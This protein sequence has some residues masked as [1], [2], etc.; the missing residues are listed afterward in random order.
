MSRKFLIICSAASLLLI[1]MSASARDRDFGLGLVLGEPTGVSG[2]IWLGRTTALDG[3]VAW[4]TGRDDDLQLQGD[5]VWHD[6]GLFDVDRGALPLY[7]GVGGRI[8]TN[9]GS[10]RLGVRFP[11]GLA[12]IF[13]GSRFDAFMEAAPT[14]DLAPRTDVELAAGIGVRYFFP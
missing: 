2:K 4:S 14:L 7:Y 9:R 1:P 12:Y 5:Y 13:A 11:V 3:A 6:F 10:D 8:R